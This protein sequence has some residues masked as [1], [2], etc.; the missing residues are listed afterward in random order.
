MLLTAL[1]SL[2][3]IA[4]FIAVVT[5]LVYPSK[6]KSLE[7]HL[8]TNVPDYAEDQAGHSVWYK[9]RQDLEGKRMRAAL[10]NIGAYAVGMFSLIAV[11][12]MLKAAGSTSH[13]VM[14]LIVAITGSMWL[15]VIR[16]AI[17]DSRKSNL[18]TK[19]RYPY[20]RQ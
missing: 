14:I 8:D 19:R 2:S 13:I 16:S 20:G 7:R 1:L 5:A 3:S 4:A 15:V 9:L 17:F 12:D 11:S 10:W 6:C 18:D